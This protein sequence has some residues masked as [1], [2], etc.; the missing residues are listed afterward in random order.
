MAGR[1]A[2]AVLI[3]AGALALFGSHWW[4]KKTRIDRQVGI[5]IG[6]GEGG[7]PIES[8]RPGYPAD[9]GGIRA[10][11]FLLAIDDLRMTRSED[12]DLAADRFKRGQPARFLVRRQ[13]AE[14]GLQV[15][16]GGEFPWGEMLMV[17]A[18]ICG[19]LAIALLAFFQPGRDIR[20]TLLSLF[21]VAI[22]FELA[23]PMNEGSLWILVAANLAFYLLSGLQYGVELHLAGSVP[24]RHP[25]LSRWPWLIK[26]FYAVGL[27]C[28]LWGVFSLLARVFEWSWSPAAIFSTANLMDYFFFPTWIIGLMVLLGTQASRHPEPLA[29]HQAG[30]I[31]L[32]I[33]PWIGMVMWITLQVL[34]GRGT[35][36]WAD[37]AWAA[38]LLPFP[39][40]V[41]IA[42]YRY[43]LFDIQLIARKG[44]VYS[45]LTGTLL[46][47]FYTLLGAGSFILS[48]FVAGGVPSVWLFA[49]TAL[50]LGLLFQKL[51][52]AVQQIIDRRFF[53]ER[54]AFRQRLI[55]LA[56]ELPMHGKVPLMGHHLVGRLKEIFRLK[57]VALFLTDA[58]AGLLYHLVSAPAEA[59]GEAA[60]IDLDDELVRLVKK[61]KKP[62][63]LERLA[64]GD[65][66]LGEEFDA[67]HLEIAVPLLVQ[68]Q[69]T[70]LLLIGRKESGKGF[71][72]EELEM[73]D[74]MSRH[75]GIVF[76]NAKL[77]ESAT[78]DN[79]TG[80]LRRESVLDKLLLELK[81]AQRYGRPITVGMVDLDHFKNVND[82][83]GHLAGDMV[84]KQVSG[85]ISRTLRGSDLMGRYGGEEFLLVFP[86]T[87]L[88]GAL[89][90]A[91][92]I[93]QEV[94]RCACR[95]AGGKK[96]RVTLSVG[97][98]VPESDV[99]D[100]VEVTELIDRA[101][102]ALL[103]AK[104]EGRNRVQVTLPR[105][106]D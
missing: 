61:A 72:S 37:L 20:K 66:P 100:M 81:R 71:T 38:V 14:L 79:L 96:I 7:I 70:G 48:G 54:R 75:V 19:Y 40:T 31:L 74:F 1:L 27:G 90:M 55:A 82:K 34:L 78:Y 28:G 84:L 104:R 97:L 26:L 76:E 68:E 9:R 65:R 21:G 89:E 8:V 62:F 46:V 58:P 67:Q 86:E 51:S 80:A 12:Y 50:L 57:S 25:W 93:R 87:D 29:R 49:G 43:H 77:F 6:R 22:A 23:L 30:L 45:A 106:K 102:Q 73:L 103:A 39:V 44:L 99:K 47:A 59:F 41:F 56:G 13:G 15:K 11:D 69:L 52:Q 92:R 105:L 35:P 36:E 95:V 42:M 18:T 33:L 88:E 64:I 53:P 24:V 10:G 5:D 91:E 101:D 85:C 2:L 3:V 94:E 16:P 63:P 4:L 60:L 17:S 98:A 32:G 83:Y